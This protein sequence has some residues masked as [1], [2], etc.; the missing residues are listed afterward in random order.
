MEG[1]KRYG[2]AYVLTAVEQL[3]YPR[4]ILTAESLFLDELPPVRSDG[5]AIVNLA[6]SASAET[7][8][9][10]GQHFGINKKF[11][12]VTYA[13][14]SNRYNCSVQES[15][16]NDTQLTCL[17]QKE[18]A[19]GEYVFTITV[20]G[21][22]SAPSQDVLRFLAVPILHSVA[23]CKAAGNG[24]MDCPTDGNVTLTV[25]GDAFTTDSVR[26]ILVQAARAI[27]ICLPSV[28]WMMTRV[29]GN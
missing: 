19:V 23:G 26:V 11:V 5:R 7:L 18:E 1:A 10:K 21:Q 14:A 12:S 27:Q 3:N 17:T 24:T 6:D 25:F 15:G 9:F 29:P 8:T 4:P 2:S 20:A 13:S 22:V 16:F 28:S